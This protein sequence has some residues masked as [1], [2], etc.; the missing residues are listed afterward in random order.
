MEEKRK[1]DIKINRPQ[2]GINPL[3][4]KINFHA[5]IIPQMR[6]E[7]AETRPI[8]KPELPAGFSQKEYVP[9]DRNLLIS[10]YSK[11]CATDK[12]RDTLRS[13]FGGFIAK[14]LFKTS[15]DNPEVRYR[16]L[17]LSPDGQTTGWGLYGVNPKEPARAK[18]GRLIMPQYQK[19]GIGT[20]LIGHLIDKCRELDPEVSQL[21]SH[22][23]PGN[24]A[25]IKSLTK[26]VE[27]YGGFRADEYG[28]SK[29]RFIF[30]L[31]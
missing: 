15:I 28:S 9:E 19:L 18:L 25:S 11:L 30:P 2:L 1:K 12:G 17:V 8:A 3:L 22:I 6:T 23:L 13:Y 7:A 10:L 29:V 5:I 20:A 4:S 27:I 24:K 21:E 26:A 31:S 14:P 16:T